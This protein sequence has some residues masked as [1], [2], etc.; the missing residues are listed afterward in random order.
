MAGTTDAPTEITANPHP[1]ELDI[2][3]ILQEIR[4]YL[5]PDISGMSCGT[6]KYPYRISVAPARPVVINTSYLLTN[7]FGTS[8]PIMCMLGW[9]QT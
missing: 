5:S 8:L 7:T 3:F 4:D 6:C 9:S 2:Q 1:K